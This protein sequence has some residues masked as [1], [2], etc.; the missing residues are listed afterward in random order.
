MLI[1]SLSGAAFFAAVTVGLSI[2]VGS[3]VARAQS[4]AQVPMQFDFMNP[5][6]RTLGLGGAFIGAGDDATTAFANPAGLALINTREVSA[7][8]RFRRQETPFL[9]GG[10]VSGG[11]TGIGADTV[12]GPSYGIDIDQQL[13]PAF[14]S[15]VV[16]VGRATIAGY[17]H[18]VARIENTFFSNGPFQRATFGS[19]T[20]DNVR[21]LPL[22][23]TR[24]VTIANYGAAVGLRLNPRWSIGGGIPPTPSTCNRASRASTS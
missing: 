7:E 16:P 17:R 24:T 18:E 12:S 4:T 15:V 22:G 2:L 19:I 21:D 23:G 9:Q 13:A 3:G 8:G 5:G 20:D 14:L 11:M 1:G 6:A 10:R